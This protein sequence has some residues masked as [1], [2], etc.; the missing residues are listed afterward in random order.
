MKSL[1]PDCYKV[2]LFYMFELFAW[3]SSLV[4]A[5]LFILAFRVLLCFGILF[6]SMFAHA[7]LAS[8]LSLCG[9][10]DI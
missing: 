3:L 5:H 4:I 10:S 2:L 8:F 9:L 6:F 7:N 1:N